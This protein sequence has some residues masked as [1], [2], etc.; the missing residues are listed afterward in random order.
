M[1][2]IGNLLSTWRRELADRDF[3]SGVFVRAVME[4]DLTLDQLN[5]GSLSDL[6]RTIR[7]KGHEAYFFEQWLNHR[8][9]FH[10][11]VSQLTAYDWR[12]VLQ[13]HDRFFAMHMGSQ[14]LI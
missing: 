9:K 4:G 14:G 2:R 3:T 1:G 7:T 8:D 5:N 10:R 11:R 6:E 13:G 12:G